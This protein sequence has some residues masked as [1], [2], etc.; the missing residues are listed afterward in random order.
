MYME[1]LKIDIE[2]FL[3]R[4]KMTKA[5]LLRRIGEDPKSSILSAYEK[6]RSYPSFE[7]CAK[8]LKAGMKVAELFGIEYRVAP[9]PSNIPK[10]YDT[11]E[12]REGVRVLFN[13]MMEEFNGKIDKERKNQRKNIKS[14]NDNV[15]E[16]ENVNDNGQ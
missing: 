11:P 4:M 6:G 1:Y 9:T 15:N 2:S 16:N 5:E 3:D 13:E 10:G 12:F 7:M 8:L 14:E